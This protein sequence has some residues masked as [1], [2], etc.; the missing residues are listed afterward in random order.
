MT[1]VLCILLTSCTVSVLAQMPSSPENNELER[2]VAD[3]LTEVL[4]TRLAGG[5]TA[6]ELHLLARAYVN[7]ARRAAT[8]DQRREAFERADALYERRLKTLQDAAATDLPAIVRLAAAHAEY[9][10]V[11]LSAQA[12]GTL[13]EFTLTL[14][15]SGDRQFLARVLG[16]ART[17][18]E[19]ALTLLAPLQADLARHED[20]L[21][22]A[23]VYDTLLQTQLDATLN[24]GW[25]SYY[26]GVLEQPPRRNE[27]L[28]S[29]E[30]HFQKLIAGGQ[31][32]AMRHVCYLGQAMAQRELGRPDVA[33]KTFAHVFAADTP[34]LVEAQARCELAR[35]QILAGK[36]DEARATLRPL[37]EKDPDRLA[38]E[39]RAL[40]FYVNLAHVWEANSY[41]VESEA[42][43]RAARDST[44]R[45][46]I[47]QKAQRVRQTGLAKFRTLARRGGAWPALVQIYVAASIETKAAVSELSAIE[48]FYVAGAL[49][50]ARR[51]DDAR[52]H[53]EEAAKRSDLDEELAGDI[54]F[55]L[56]RCQ[57]LLKDER[58]SATTFAQ[59]A[60]TRRR[61]PQAAQAATFALTL[62]LR[63]AEESRAPA[64]YQQLAEVARNLVE[65][66]AD[67]P[68][69]VEA[70]WL[71]PVAL[72]LAGNWG[73][74]AEEFAKVPPDSPHWEEAQYRRAQCQL[75]LV[76]SRRDR[77]TTEEYQ[78]QTRR[79][80]AALRRYAEEARQRASRKLE[81][82]DVR[83]WAAEATL[84]AAELLSSTGVEDYQAALEALTDFE[85]AY[86][87]S[88]LLGRVLAVRLRAYRGLRRFEQAAAILEQFLRAAP[89]EQVGPTLAALAAA[90]QEQV[91]SLSENGETEAARALATESLTTF[92]ELLKWVQADQ[93]RQ[94][95]LEPVQ[96]AR[97]Q[98]LYYA[99]RLPA[100]Q[101]A[102]SEL[103]A[104][105]PRNGNYQHL[106]A[107]ILTG[108]LGDA[109]STDDLRRAQQAWEALLADPSIL[110]HAPQRYWEA[111]YNWLA[112]ALRLGRA[113]DVAT[114]I[115]QE[116][117]WRPDLGGP[118]WHT[119]LLQLLAAAQAAA[120]QPSATRPDRH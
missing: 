107:L 43:R 19:R 94:A 71:L 86:P 109:A 78:A 85:T 101:E 12:A 8:S 31:A 42:L 26:L 11:L 3:G 84:A 59:L 117:I 99:G 55:E 92:D 38:P 103:L 106:S 118:P 39:E 108:Q 65:N 100:A 77:V 114:A 61:H 62:W 35:C 49:R 23:G 51:Y 73:Q 30:R 33:E 41:L 24:Q 52:L 37:V 58:A 54:L 115:T 20:T 81:H 4:E 9:A 102:V 34:P 40:R 112:L 93:G 6:D 18:Y 48:L 116:R 97:A 104:R 57:Y 47:I 25:A 13:D 79:A 44:A 110:Q 91:R 50:E 90:V 46:A 64:D 22:A 95:H 36:Y 2:L 60:A 32:G 63:V 7:K 28:S 96:A 67:H 16:R 69:R 45:T 5:R 82:A 74:A 70:L 105:N 89:P 14:G 87:D 1:R 66:Y 56:G 10:G 68:R 119:K 98:M 111:R 17:H 88:N 72:Q 15:R 53:L 75:Q 120:G 80:A 113:T 29:A 27:L 76:Q 21:L 83:R